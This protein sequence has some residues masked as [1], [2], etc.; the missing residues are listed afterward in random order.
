MSGLEVDGAA[1][2][3]ALRRLRRRPRRQPAVSAAARAWAVTRGGPS[4]PPGPCE[5]STAA[6]NDSAKSRRCVQNRATAPFFPAELLHCNEH[7]QRRFLPHCGR[8]P[9]TPPPP[10][11]P[12]SS[13]FPGPLLALPSSPCRGGRFSAFRST[14]H[15]II[16]SKPSRSKYRTRFVPRFGDQL[17]YG[18]R[19]R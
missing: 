6:N 19:H 5:A 8:L 13:V 12:H 7:H 18:M 17:C 10:P 14:R 3:G 9:F 4:P 15:H 16:V 1:E 11:P 2:F